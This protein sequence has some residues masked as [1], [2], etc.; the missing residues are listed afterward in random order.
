VPKVLGLKDLIKRQVMFVFNFIS[1]LYFFVITTQYVHFL[2]GE[3]EFVITIYW[4]VLALAFL[5]YGIQR[6]LIRMRTIGL[7]IL[8]LTVI[9]I[10]AFDIWSS[11][12]NAIMRVIALMMVGGIM[13]AI[14][15]LYGKKY[16]GDLKGEFNF[17]NLTSAK[18][19]IIQYEIIK[20]SSQISRGFFDI[21]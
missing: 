12:D 10:L 3:T 18:K 2:F 8:S 6:D 14:S 11:L 9:K 19:D 13:I 20:K 17:E 1:S 7:Y 15:V 21:V 16:G 4:G 5:T